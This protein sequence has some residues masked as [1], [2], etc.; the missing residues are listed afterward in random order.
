MK[1]QYFVLIVISTILLL[2]CAQ[3][4]KGQEQPVNLI[5]VKNKI[6]YTT[7]SGAVETWRNCYDKA[8][9]TCPNGYKIS[10]KTEN[11]NGGYR[12][13]TFSCI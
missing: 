3:L 1:H 2:G 5:N 4:M 6:F 13:I 12:T 9:R 10:D 7:C 8:S 11:A